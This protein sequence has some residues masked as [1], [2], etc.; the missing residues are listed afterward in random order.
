MKSDIE[1]SLEVLR[2]GGVILYPTDTIWG[3]GCDATNSSAVERIFAIKKRH[4]S[5]SLIILVNSIDML[6]KYVDGIPPAAFEILNVADK[7]LTIVYPAGRNLAAGVC[8]EDGS[9]G[10]R[11]TSDTFCSSL[12]GR[13]GRPIVSTSANESGQ[14]S[15][16]NFSEITESIINA[17]DYVVTI[18]RDE[19]RQ[20]K[21]SPVIKV[22]MNGVIKILRM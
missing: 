2:N 12:I 13:L 17:A 10:I 22:E 11:L 15:P 8:A 9:I 1:K 5:K 21:A 7:P 16:R 18:R 20:V 3:L 14:P 19:R 4:D 6:E